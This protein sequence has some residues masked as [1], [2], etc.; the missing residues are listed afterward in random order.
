MFLDVAVGIF[1]AFI[2]GW[3]FSIPVDPRWL[4]LG[5]G[6]ALLPDIDV[7]PE[8]L[9]RG[10]LGGKEE[11]IHRTWTH[12]PLLF[13]LPILAIHIFFGLPAAVLAAAGMYAHV[14][15]DSMGE[16]WGIRWLAPVNFRNFKLFSRKTGEFDWG[17][18]LVSWEPDELAATMREHGNENWVRDFYLRP[19]PTLFVEV[20]ALLAALFLV[21][22]YFD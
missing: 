12:Y 20:L 18:R 9:R 7:I 19:T 13:P 21:L 6:F 2:T 16:G 8:L 15:H 22:R 5:I 10:R 4:G 1:L 14:I 17:T 11:G 3:A